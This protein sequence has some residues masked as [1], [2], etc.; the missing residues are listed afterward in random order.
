MKFCSASDSTTSEAYTA[1]KQAALYLELTNQAKYDPSGATISGSPSVF[2][3]LV[4][5][6][7]PQMTRWHYRQDGNAIVS[8]NTDGSGTGVT[9]TGSACNTYQN[10]T[11]YGKNT[12]KTNSNTRYYY[13]LDAIRANESK[14]DAENLLLSGALTVG[15]HSQYLR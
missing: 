7:E 12:V 8:I 14:S 1:D 11:T 10:K 3:E 15:A 4:A 13:N 6:A 9:M 5:Y 2:D